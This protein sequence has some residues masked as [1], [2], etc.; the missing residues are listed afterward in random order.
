ME[1]I[2]MKYQILFSGK[3]KKKFANL[4]SAEFAQKV[5]K[6]KCVFS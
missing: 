4:L 5:V 2:C 3:T 6:V 1:T